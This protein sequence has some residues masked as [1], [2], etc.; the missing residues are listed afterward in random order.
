MTTLSPKYGLNP[1]IPVCM[2]C[3]KE[4]NEL[5]L[6][7]RVRSKKYAR[8]DIEMPMS[9]V[10]DTIPCDSCAEKFST[11]VICTEV[12]PVDNE[13]QKKHPKPTG[14]Y[15]V[16]NPECFKGKHKAGDLLH[17]PS[18]VFEVM[19]GEVIKEMEENKNA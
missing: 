6:F 4:K 15:F 7:G 13:E 10:L 1:C 19:F 3:G 2:Y 16:V 12:F 18:D 17:I 9:A 14:R 11:G 5:R 8:D